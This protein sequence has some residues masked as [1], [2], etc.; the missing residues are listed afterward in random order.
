MFKKSLGFALFGL[1]ISASMMACISPN[2]PYKKE[3]TKGIETDMVQHKKYGIYFETA[4]S[5]W[6]GPVS[7]NKKFYNAKI[8]V[9]T[10]EPRQVLLQGSE[11]EEYQSAP[12]NYNWLMQQEILE[13]S[14][15]R[16]EDWWI[17]VAIC[18]FL[19]FLVT[20]FLLF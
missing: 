20:I 3:F 17:S 14:D 1:G 5:F 8:Y 4:K 19:L 18:L 13:G 15:A 6:G 16:L 12:K 10:P 2:D 7:S 11:T 9:R